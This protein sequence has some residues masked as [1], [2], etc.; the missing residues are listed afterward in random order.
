MPGFQL[1][2]GPGFAPSRVAPAYQ[3]VSFG[4]AQ[5]LQ[6]NPRQ[7]Y[8]Q[9]A[10]Q[11]EEKPGL[12]AMLGQSLGEGIGAGL[13][14]GIN[15][16]FEEYNKGREAERQ[17]E[18]NRIQIEGMR[19]YLKSKGMSD[20]TINGLSQAGY[21]PKEAR[22]LA[23]LNEEEAKR[24]SM[25]GEPINKE[26]AMQKYQNV[27]NKIAGIENSQAQKGIQTEQE[28][29]LPGQMQ[30]EQNQRQ[31]IQPK[32]PTLGEDP[33]LMAEIQSLP[34]DLKDSSLEAYKNNIKINQDA[35]KANQERSKSELAETRKLAI[36][37]QKMLNES[38]KMKAIR[39]K[40]NLGPMA[41]WQMHGI[42]PE[43]AQKRKEIAYYE[44]SAITQFGFIK[45][46][47]LNRMTQQ[48]FGAVGDR[49]II[50]PFDD[51]ATNAGKEKFF[52]DFANNILQQAI[53][54][55]S[56]EKQGMLPTNI[57]ELVEQRFGPQMDEITKILSEET[58][59]QYLNSKTYN[60]GDVVPE[61]A[62]ANVF[63][64]GFLRRN[65]NTGQLQVSN[66]LSWI[67]IPEK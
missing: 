22:F 63:P 27:M 29:V 9:A 6:Q 55:E 7:G 15:Q 34:K 25:Y 59:V 5:F 46:N 56:L 67:E 2:S 48:E 64:A 1:P 14:L 3:P 47:L 24:K 16:K 42:G 61:N 12:G 32:Y 33:A 50:S 49:W 38:K 41:R 31:P 45:E 57:T 10:L 60:Q 4:Q 20:E 37:A 28:Q 17:R 43:K 65:R 40:G 62:K 21:D 13:K 11:Q 18:S 35:I 26:L 39:A 8:V 23:E 54:V 53:F 44:N 58:P 19:S 51:D 66:G 36:S 30:S 52:E